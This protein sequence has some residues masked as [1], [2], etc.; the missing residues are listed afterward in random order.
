MARTSSSSRCKGNFIVHRVKVMFLKRMNVLLSKGRQFRKL[1]RARVDHK[2]HR[3]QG[4]AA[5][6]KS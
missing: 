2:G 4:E 5:E 1:E 3:L 6:E